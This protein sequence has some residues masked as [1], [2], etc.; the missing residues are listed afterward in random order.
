MRI[1]EKLEITSPAFED[2]GI[3][4]IEYTGYGRDC[5]PTLILENLK[6]DA[7]SLAVIMVDLDIP[8]IREYPH[9]LI[10]NLPVTAEI[11]G[12]LPKSEHLPE[13][14]G[15]QQG[16]AYGKH[17]YRGPKPPAFLRKPHRYVF[18]VYVLDV[19]LDL[20]SDAKQAELLK[21]MEGH[22]LQRGEITG[23]YRKN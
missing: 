23:L 19:R 8:F 2:D 11:P 9:W 15:A 3:I 17:Q 14:S 18:T 13:L 4:P 1:D 20:D 7:V 16:I 5:S 12:S 10:W 6:S 22:I 21:A